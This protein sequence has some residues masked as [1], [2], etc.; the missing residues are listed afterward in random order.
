[1][2]I[3]NRYKLPAAA[4]PMVFAFIIAV[5]LGGVMCAMITAITTGLTAGFLA[6]WLQAYALAFALG[7]PAVTFLAPIVRRVVARQ[8]N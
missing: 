8:T 2:P 6:R 1:M 3:D 4:T 5:S 7:F